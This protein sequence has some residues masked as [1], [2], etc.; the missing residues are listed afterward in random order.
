MGLAEEQANLMISAIEIRKKSV[1]ELLI[2]YS[3][4]FSLEFETPLGQNDINEIL[5]KGFSRIPVY[6]GPNRNNLLGLLR[7]KQLVGYNFSKP[8]SLKDLDIQLKKPLVI[9]P[10]LKVIDLLREFLKMTFYCCKL[11]FL[12][13]S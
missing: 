3:S 7:I 2:P 6:S 12:I 10:A 11:D 1:S 8:K 13:F 5:S 9:S 4:T